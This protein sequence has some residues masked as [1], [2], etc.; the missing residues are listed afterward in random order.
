MWNQRL[1]HVHAISWT[2]KTHADRMDM[3][4]ALIPHDSEIKFKVSAHEFGFN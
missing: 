1:F 3:E 2:Q 4:K